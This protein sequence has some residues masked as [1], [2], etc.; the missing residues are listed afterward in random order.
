MSSYSSSSSSSSASSVVSSYRHGQHQ[1]DRNARISPD[2][3]MVR[4]FKDPNLR[5]P[6]LTKVEAKLGIDNWAHSSAGCLNRSQW[7]STHSP[8]AGIAWKGMTPSPLQH[9]F[10][11]LD[12]NKEGKNRSDSSGTGLA[13]ATMVA[14]NYGASPPIFSGNS[15]E[16]ETAFVPTG[17]PSPSS[18][19]RIPP[20][21]R[22]G[23]I[24][25]R[26]KARGFSKRVVQFLMGGNRE[27]T[28]ACYQ[29]HGTMAHL[30]G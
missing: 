3:S 12:K 2:S 19:A 1:D 23:V 8:L 22:L 16:H 9:D 17:Q 7:R 25:D 30:V 24:R 20:G 27:S 10:Q 6:D 5:G 4:C 29:T 15:T 28:T 26:F 21:C 13:S 11:M 18:D 14:D